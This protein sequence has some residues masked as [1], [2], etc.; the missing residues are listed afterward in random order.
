[1]ATLT[2]N[3][4]GDLNLGNLR[5]E[6][7]TLQPAVADYVP[8]GY[9]L[10]QIAGASVG[11]G[12][13]G[14]A[15]I[16]GVIPVGGQ[17]GL[18]P[19]WNPATQKLQ[20]LEPGS[21][22]STPVVVGPVSAAKSTLSAVATGVGAVTIANSLK[23]GQF[24]LL[25]SFTQLGALNGAVVQVTSATA[26]QFTFNL[27]SAS[28]VTAGADT[29]GTYQLVQAGS[30]NAVLGGTAATITN[31]LATTS[32]ITMTC[33]NTFVP[34]QFVV[35]QGLINGAVANGVIVQIATASATQFTANWTGTA[36][37]SGAETT[38]TA[39]P[40]VT[41]GAA[42]IVAASA[43]TVSNSLA[44]ASSAGVAG[45]ITLTAV[46]SFLPGQLVVP[47]ALVNGA[48]INGDI[49]VVNQASL[50]T[51][52]FVANHPT[53]A[54][55]TGA[56][57]GTVSGLV[58]GVVPGLSIANSEVQAGTDLSAYAFQLLVIGL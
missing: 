47:Q 24:V 41:S 58:S 42:P 35:L 46:Q 19:A 48:A 25:Q 6:L 13:V 11:T 22:D 15:K 20:I 1:M 23:A 36:I 44:T 29:T 12:N 10:Q 33:A 30:G 49:L 55:S 5:A 18:S 39:A 51:K 53:A 27:G 31:S 38:A 56:D 4:D 54:I 21:T 26:T 50:T 3:A 9:T 32:L 14:M 7:I 57:T 43:T 52:Q 34:G 37:S 28:N 45:V 2:K 16:L 8:G 17:A 40:L